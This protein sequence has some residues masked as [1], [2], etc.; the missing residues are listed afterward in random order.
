MLVLLFFAF[1]LLVLGCALFYHQRKK[2]FYPV[3]KEIEKDALP[4]TFEGLCSLFQRN[5]AIIV[6]QVFNEAEQQLV[7]QIGEAI[8]FCPSANHIGEFYQTHFTIDA[9]T[10]TINV[11]PNLHNFDKCEQSVT[12]TQKVQVKQLSNHVDK[13][14]KLFPHFILN[15]GWF[16]RFTMGCYCTDHQD[17]LSFKGNV[18]LA[19]FGDYS[20]GEFLVEHQ[21]TKAKSGDIILL[22][23]NFPGFV[24]RFQKN[25]MPL[26]SVEP[27]K[28]GARYS[29]ILNS[30]LP[31]EKCNFKKEK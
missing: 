4:L 18:I 21:Q 22:R 6:R 5:S 26:H 15:D 24:N 16:H 1:V 30:N 23:A 25:F 3:F 10:Q 13:I 27:V 12:K 8:H 11:Y 9:D 31:F 28:S 7:L 29:L 20:G 14:R 19:I 2:R 17:P